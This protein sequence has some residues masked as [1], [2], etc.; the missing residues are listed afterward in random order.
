MPRFTD[1]QEISFDVYP[2]ERL[3]T[4]KA[5]GGTL[6]TSVFDGTEFVD[7]DVISADSSSVLFTSGARIKFTPAG[8]AT[9]SIDTTGRAS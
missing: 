6:T 3:L 5:N 8:G 2:P 7:S 1:E 4:V 9:Y